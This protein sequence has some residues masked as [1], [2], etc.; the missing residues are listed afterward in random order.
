MHILRV[1]KASQTLFNN[2]PTVVGMRTFVCTR[3]AITLQERYRERG[4]RA[5]AN[6]RH[7][8]WCMVKPEALG[9]TDVGKGTRCANNYHAPLSNASLALANPRHVAWCMVKPGGMVASREGGDMVKPGGYGGEQRRR[10]Y[11][12]TGGVWWRAEKEAR[13]RNAGVVDKPSASVSC[14]VKNV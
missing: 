12:K 11:G 8:P 4:E 7:V 9:Y 10:R 3:S 1:A 2:F 14:H 5:F 13:E 6:L